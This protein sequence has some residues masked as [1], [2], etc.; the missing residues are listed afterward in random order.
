MIIDLLELD[1][2][3]VTTYPSK[4]YESNFV[5]RVGDTIVIKKL[6]RNYDYVVVSVIVNPETPNLVRVHIK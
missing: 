4:T 6:M 5:P 3:N 1:F 2:N